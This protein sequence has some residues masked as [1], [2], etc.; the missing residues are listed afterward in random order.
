MIY[1]VIDDF[2][3]YL[4][5]VLQYI[6]SVYLY[7]SVMTDDFTPNSD[8]NLLVVTPNP[9]TDVQAQRLTTARQ[10]LAEVRESKDFL[11]INGAIICQA[12]LLSGKPSSNVLYYGKGKQYQDDVYPLTTL[13]KLALKTQS[14]LLV[15]DDVLA[16][17][18]MPL[19]SQVFAECQRV[20]QSVATIG[21]ADG[22]T[23]AYECMFWLT[24]ALYTVATNDVASKSDSMLWAMEQGYLAEK[25]AMQCLAY[26]VTESKQYN[27]KMK[28]NLS[29]KSWQTQID[30]LVSKAGDVVGKPDTY[31]PTVEIFYNGD[32]NEPKQTGK[33]TW[34]RR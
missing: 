8:V 14:K 15:G 10:F 32:E 5:Q 24:R 18:D 22:T 29:S 25:V 11:R 2:V 4:Q 16:K 34:K 26:H 23:F 19:R 13:D 7:G 9:L 1:T 20:V 12:D 33:L 31:V 21:K 30:S 28:Q 3:D 17:L 6:P 27:A